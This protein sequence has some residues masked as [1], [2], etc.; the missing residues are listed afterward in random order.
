MLRAAEREATWPS[1]SLGVSYFAPTTFMPFNGYG[2][3]AAMSLP[4]LWGG[5]DRRRDA[6]RQYAAAATTEIDG[7]RVQIDADVVT[8]ESSVRAAALRLQVL[9]ERVLPATKRAFDLAWGGYES[10]RTD[11]LTQ[12]AANRSVV[13]AEHDV[14][15]SRALLDHALADLDAAVGAPVPRQPLGPLVAGGGEASHG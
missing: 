3:N 5:A 13:E 15:M 4:W 2:V 1:F 6:Q 10:G 7:V 11:L 8:A 14:V 12:V 9:R